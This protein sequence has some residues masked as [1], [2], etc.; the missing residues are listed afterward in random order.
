MVYIGLVLTSMGFLIPG[1]MAWRRRFRKGREID[2]ITSAVLSTSSILYHG[3]L[4]PLA[5]RFDIFVAH[6]VGLLSIGR[7]ML[8]VIAWRR[9]WIELGILGGTLG[10]IGV[11]L[12]K[13]RANPHDNCKYWH[14]LFHLSG[15]ATWVSHILTFPI[16]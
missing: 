11:Y 4:H 9:G 8:N 7:S 3:T 1:W 14:M 13:S 15:Q 6:G 16:H 10:S 5:H 12:C 2:I